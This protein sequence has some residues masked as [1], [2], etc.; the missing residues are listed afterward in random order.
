MMDDPLA[1]ATALLADAEF[2]ALAAFLATF[3][4]EDLA[5]VAAGLLAADG[6]ATIGALIAAL[7]AGVLIGDLGLYGL[8]KLAARF[9]AI[10]R[11]IGPGRVEAGR[12]FLERR[13]IMA[14]LV[15]RMT[16]GARLPTYVAAGYVGA[17]FTR[18]CLAAIPA[19][20]CWTLALFFAAY[21]IGAAAVSGLAN[22]QWVAAALLLATTAWVFRKRLLRPFRA[23]RADG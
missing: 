8:G 3:I 2:I 21:G 12:A 13:T 20:V 7:M 6:R 10:E 14:V 17:S 23:G 16:P 19:A 5:I 1:S 9:P 11:L 4:L 22:L 15:S 18:F